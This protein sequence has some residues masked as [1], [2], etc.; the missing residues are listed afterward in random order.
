M[1][2]L[3][4]QIARTVD[5]LKRSQERGNDRWVYRHGE[6]LESISRN[7]LPS[8][9]GFD[10]GTEIDLDESSADRLVLRTSFH[11]MSEH[12]YIGWSHWRIV[13]TPNLMFGCSVEVEC[14]DEQPDPDHDVESMADYIGEV[15]DHDLNEPIKE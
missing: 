11:H 12:G 10:S 3:Y 7:L 4:Q 15:F 5:A 9:S 14:L 13:V 8:G 6:T 2:R 1:T